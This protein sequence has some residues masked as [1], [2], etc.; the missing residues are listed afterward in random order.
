MMYFIF[1][2]VLVVM[3]VV[4]NYLIE[5]F[6]TKGSWIWNIAIGLVIGGAFHVFNYLVT[7]TFT[8]DCWPVYLELGLFAVICIVF[9][10]MRTSDGDTP[11]DLDNNVIQATTFGALI[12]V[13]VLGLGLLIYQWDFFHSGSKQEMLNPTEVTIETTDSIVAATDVKNLCT[14]SEEVARKA[15]MVQMG[16]LKNTYEIGSLT[17][18]SATC[19]FEATLSNGK[20]VRIK[21][22][23][24]IIYVGVLEH[25]SFWTWSKQKYSPA[26]V[27]ADASDADK[28]YVVTAVDGKELKIAYTNGAYFSHNLERHMRFN[29]YAGTILADFDMEINEQ[30]L[31]FA[32]VTTME[33]SIGMGTPVVTGVAVVDLQSGDIKQ[34][35]PENAPAFI[36]MIQPAD[37]IY[38]RINW[39]GDYI[40]GYFHWTEK[41]GLTQACEGMDVV[42]TPSGCYYYVGIRAQTDAVGTQGYMLIDTRTGKA[43]YYRRS[44]ISEA[45]A[46]RVLEA[47]TDLNLEM[48]SGVLSLTEPIFYNIEGLPTYFST[49]VS[50]NDYMVKYYGFCSTTD[51][52]VWGYGKT[53]EEARANY[54]SSYYKN[55]SGKS[56]K[57]AEK[58]TL[59]EIEVI[60]LEKSNINDVFY[61][62]FDGYSDKVFVAS[63]TPEMSDILWNAK[64]VKVS[65]SE[66]DAK[67]VTLSSYEIIN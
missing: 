34:Y 14:V 30:G 48:K 53:L 59:Q 12:A 20:K 11:L 17:K 19:D 37:V 22:D 60:V 47:N 55:E 5:K 24:H 8:Y 16:D 33:N 27:I 9:G 29:G 35:T 63:L 28:V 62:R 43:T 2:V 4:F 64:K 13:V 25:R 32:P 65:F 31:P 58:Q 46:T 52:S 18:Q 66:T 57:F 26:Y 45:E 67:F 38:D 10:S 51:K 3:Y 56:V 42:Q 36:N 61:F 54:L 15:I 6:Q 23:D 49:Y 21:Y 40:Y 39:W 1:S 7:P 50:T 44:G 41:S